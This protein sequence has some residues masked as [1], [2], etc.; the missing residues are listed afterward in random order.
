MY[1]DINLIPFRNDKYYQTFYTM[2]QDN[3]VLHTLRGDEYSDDYIDINL[4]RTQTNNVLCCDITIV[5]KQDFAPE[6]FG[7]RLGLDTYMD[8][9]PDWNDKVF[10][11]SLRCE[12]NGFWGCFV[13]PLGLKVAVASKD[14]I[15]CYKNEYNG[16]SIAGHRIY[17]TS[18]EFINNLKL[19]KRHS[20]CNSFEKG[21][22]YTYKLY[23]AVVND[24]FELKKFILDYAN[25]KLL[26]LEKYTLEPHEINDGTYKSLGVDNADYGIHHI[27]KQGCSAVSYYV[28]RDWLYYLER[29]NESAK[30]CQQKAG[31]HA[32]SWY[33][34]F[35]RVAYCK[36]T[37][38]D[39]DKEILVNDF[40]K[41]YKVLA[42]RN[43]KML[44]KGTI[45]HRLQNSSAMISLLTD[46]YEL[47]QD[48][49][50]LD[51]ANYLAEWLMKLQ[52]KDGS[53]RSGR[54]HYTCVI[55][56]AKSM[57][58]L[59]LAEKTAG[60]K[61]RYNIHF[62]S[63][64][65]AVEDLARNLDNIETEGEMTFEDGMISC[66]ALQLAYMALNVEDVQLKEKFAQA[67]K[68]IMNKHAC[69]EQTYVPD[70][71][72]HGATLRFW[73]ARYDINFFANMM[74]S[75]HGWTSWKNY[76][77]YYL[78]LLTGESK[79]LVDTMNT[80][81]A[82]MQCV[83]KDGVLN[84][85]F[86]TDPCVSGLA[87]EKADNRLGL[88]IKRKTIGEEYLPMVSDWYRQNPKRLIFQ[89][90]ISLKGISKWRY[91]FGGSCD[92]D[93][94]E[95]FKCLAETVLD[96]AFIHENSDKTICYSCK[97]NNNV[98]DIISP[99]TKQLIFYCIKEKDIIL[100]DKTI[101]LSKGFNYINI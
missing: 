14:N 33:G 58:E 93:V 48:L 16:N 4:V 35:S 12:K 50:Y 77:T 90:F 39:S 41:F 37:K 13:S 22:T 101:R 66:E 29:A 69:L 32:E 5:A 43:K 82:C 76:A 92:N 84:W 7:F 83:D 27:E 67:G 2:N 28:R 46:F 9:Y 94:H 72:S 3:I 20:Q 68:L 57:L 65:R 49:K 45:T 18:V 47:T 80:I 40:E 56:P 30:V 34:F 44:R 10:P 81:G 25:I 24:Y 75:P 71:R 85:G 79:Y 55:Y 6:R 70:C 53:Y 54:T 11:T 86:I 87:M 61:E 19:P 21:K 38:K 78:Y 96:K 23:F 42:V 52:S 97:F 1:N 17:T 31:T 98:V 26:Q 95:H 99:Y 63:S 15:V 36:I 8:K 100:N 51:W 88:T 59:A 60:L 91:D 89:Y 73:E 62:N 64:L 74:I